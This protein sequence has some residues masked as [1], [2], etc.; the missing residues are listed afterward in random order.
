M[1]PNTKNNS[2]QVKR[3]LYSKKKVKAKD[4]GER[5]DGV[6]NAK[7]LRDLEEIFAR[8]SQPE[9]STFEGSVLLPSMT[10]SMR[11]NGKKY[12]YPF[13][14]AT[15]KS[16]TMQTTTSTTLTPKP[17][18]IKA[19]YDV[20]VCIFRVFDC[21]GDGQCDPFLQ[22]KLRRQSTKELGPNP[23]NLRFP[24]THTQ[25]QTAATVAEGAESTSTYKSAADKIIREWFPEHT[26]IDYKC[27]RTDPVTGE[28]YV[29]YE[30]TGTTANAQYSESGPMSINDEWWW[31]CVHEIMNR[32]K[33]LSLDI[34]ATVVDLFEHIPSAMFLYDGVT[35]NIMET[36]HVLYSGITEG[37]SMDEMVLLGP[38]KL[39]DNTFFKSGAGDAAD[40]AD[41]GASAVDANERR[42]YGS[43]Y[44]LYEYESVFRSACYRYSYDK[45][46][47]V[48]RSEP[49]IFRHAVF[50]GTTSTT[51]FD[52][53][54]TTTNPSIADVQN[55]ANTSWCSMNGY[56]SAHH[57]KYELST[58]KRAGGSQQLDPVFCVCNNERIV[59][60][61]YYK[62]DVESVPVKFD[63]SESAVSNYE[64]L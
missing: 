7:K 57:G 19:K 59:Q 25:Q 52:T 51:I 47:Y 41:A 43:Q 6:D 61:G 34:H 20:N 14:A 31:V 40:A 11:T 35:G 16:N 17:K 36:P 4:I 18:K 50:L 9:E 8:H 24:Y 15:S 53:D 62:I 26:N 10:D 64:L 44:Y 3:M 1:L 45:N 37:S 63:G 2:D 49:H 55:Y 12:I 46:R 13:V 38:R 33:I 32:S 39:I 54:N 60:L 28:I 21:G 27:V 56:K 5:V 48:K 42:I 29:I 22:F 30:E 23:P 58:K